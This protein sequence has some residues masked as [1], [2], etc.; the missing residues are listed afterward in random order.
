MLLLLLLPDP[1]GQVII[2]PAKQLPPD[3]LPSGYP[4]NSCCCCCFLIL[5]GKPSPLLSSFRLSYY[6]PL[7]LNTRT[8]VAS[9][10]LLLL[11]LLLCCRASRLRC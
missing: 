5:Q 2:T 7:N 9:T 4:S 6:T 10:L 11:L 3:Y 8:H 1:T